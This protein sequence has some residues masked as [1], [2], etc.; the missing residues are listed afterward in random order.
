MI[1]DKSTSG[2]G[3][4]DRRAAALPT[5]L[6][7]VSA[8]LVAGLAMGSLSTL[9]LQFNRR[10]MDTTRAE[11]AARSGLAYFLSRTQQFEAGEEQEINPLDPQPVSMTDVFPEG[12]RVTEGDYTVTMHFDQEKDYY[13]TDN[14][15]GEEPRV[16][17]HDADDVPRVP[18]YGLDLV[19][20]VEGPRRTHRY[21]AVLKR[22]WPFAVYSK[23]GTIC[24]M[25]Q[26][27]LK[28]P[29]SLNS[30]TLVE[31]D[32]Y[33]EWRVTDPKTG[34]PIV[35]EGRVKGY[36]LGDMD[37]PSQMMA[38]LEARTGYQPW[39]VP[40]HPLILGMEGHLNNPPTKRGLEWVEDEDGEKVEAF[41]YYEP[42]SWEYGEWPRKWGETEFSRVDRDLVF[43][44]PAGYPP[45]V[46]YN[47]VGNIL[48]GDL[49]YSHEANMETREW[50]IDQSTPGSYP[51]S[52]WD[53]SINIRRGDVHLRRPPARDPLSSIDGSDAFDDGDFSTIVPPIVPDS[54]LVDYA[55]SKSS[56]AGDLVAD[57][58]ATS[59]LT[60]NVVL[61]EGDAQINGTPV[62][63]GPQSTISGSISNRQVLWDKEKQRLYVR[64]SNAGL[65]LQGTTLRV[66]GDL[67]LGASAFEPV[68]RDG[69][70]IKENPIQISGAGATLIVDG[71]LVLGNA[72]INAGDQAFV[73]YARDIVI[74]A[75]GHF[76]GLLIAS[77]SISILS[78]DEQ[79]LYIEGG[80]ACAD[81]ELGGGITIRGAHVKHEPRFLKGIN[82]AGDFYLA[83]WRKI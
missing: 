45:G 16:G 7:L 11:M 9:S 8:V 5:V 80:M 67:N 53:S 12:L 69:D 59:F 39:K 1:G 54:E 4:A 40:Y 14:L 50:A 83:S 34:G 19:I 58:P 61:T 29:P 37:S 66:D 23:H 33:T 74:K 21:R 47:E 51:P 10:Q 26:P 75:G 65:D 20:S 24:L 57:L 62:G 25:G 3:G 48:D 32:V 18:P 78:Q 79:P 30:P 52:T 56:L 41:Y 64:E 60:K 38:N 44:P 22:Y 72:N 42:S 46:K 2:K 35:F 68:D 15:A 49:Y 55:V 63:G 28:P 70:G 82:G 43:P 71:Q 73:I 36:G 27:E 81:E 31:G 13:S 17:F 77:R 6:A 76:K